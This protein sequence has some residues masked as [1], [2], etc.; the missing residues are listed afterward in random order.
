ML[1][2]V[3]TSEQ[4][5][6]YLAGS[7]MHA[8]DHGVGWREE[9]ARVDRFEWLNPLDVYQHSEADIEEEWTDE[10][11]VEKDLDMIDRLDALLV[12]WDESIPS[13]GSP[14]EV[15]YA[16]RRPQK[17]VVVC[18]DEE[19]S[20]WMTYHADVVVPDMDNAF[21]ALQQLLYGESGGVVEE[22]DASYDAASDIEAISEE[23]SEVMNP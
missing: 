8:D 17:V 4:P 6:V 12:N 11:I 16:A 15:F 22:T 1:V 3:D 23:R 13:T 9:V 5:S 10:R 2:S 21:V 7:V 18:D 14:M 20:P 19:I